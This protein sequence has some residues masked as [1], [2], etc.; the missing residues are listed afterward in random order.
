[1]LVINHAWNQWRTSCCTAISVVNTGHVLQR[2]G[3]FHVC[4]RFQDQVVPPVRI[5]KVG[6]FTAASDSLIGQ[7][8]PGQVYC[9]RIDD[10]EDDLDAI[11][12]IRQRL[13][14]SVT[15]TC[16]E[17][18]CCII[19]N[20]LDSRSL[21]R[22]LRPHNIRLALYPVKGFHKLVFNTVR[23]LQTG[24]LDVASP[25]EVRIHDRGQFKETS[26]R[27]QRDH[28]VFILVREQVSTKDGRVYTAASDTCTFSSDNL[29]VLVG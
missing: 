6:D 24:H 29:T 11:L 15:V 25:G 5:R 23:D 14:W 19:L 2:T 16:F 7:R 10:T 3:D 22:S 20:Q 18:G 26:S 13:T 17:T 8:D 28:T 9:T 27:F 12:R 4:T 1:M 21:I